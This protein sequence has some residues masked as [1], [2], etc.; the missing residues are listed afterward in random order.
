MYK[1]VMGLGI[2]ISSSVRRESEASRAYIDEWFLEDSVC[3]GH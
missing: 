1:C 2:V 3:W